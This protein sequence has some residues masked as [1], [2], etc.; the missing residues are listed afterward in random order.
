MESDGAPAGNASLLLK[1]KQNI[2]KIN[3]NLRKK[4]S[5]LLK[6]SHYLEQVNWS[7]TEKSYSGLK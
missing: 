6:G 5:M 4:E 2:C 3:K 1:S 7:N